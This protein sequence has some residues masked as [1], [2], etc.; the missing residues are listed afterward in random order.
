MPLYKPL[1]TCSHDIT[2]TTVFDDKQI[3]SIAM[4]RDVT[5][6]QQSAF[7]RPVDYYAAIPLRIVSTLLNSNVR[8]FGSTPP[9]VD[10]KQGTRRCL[11]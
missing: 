6:V 11:T 1:F 9:Q 2:P 10:P 4:I 8:R 5:N 7:V 3:A